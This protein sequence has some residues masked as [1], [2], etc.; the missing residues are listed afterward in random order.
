MKYRNQELV[1]LTE[2][3]IFNPPKMMCLWN[4][5]FTDKD[6]H[7]H[8]V[9]AI[10]CYDEGHFVYSPETDVIYT[11]TKAVTRQGHFYQ[12]CAELPPELPE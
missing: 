10:I 5:G 6:I 7:V 9:S 1:E 11:T 4:D 12:H 8:Y 3:Q 2:P